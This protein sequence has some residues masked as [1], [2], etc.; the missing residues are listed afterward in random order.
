MR[1]FNKTIFWTLGASMLLIIAILA[2]TSLIVPNDDNERDSG[3]TY[4]VTDTL[5]YKK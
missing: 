4:L 5:K 2:I 3:P 1:E